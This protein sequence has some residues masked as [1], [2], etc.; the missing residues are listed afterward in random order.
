MTKEHTA[1]QNFRLVTQEAPVY[2]FAQTVAPVV[3]LPNTPPS[4]E[5]PEVNVAGR[6]GATTPRLCGNCSSTSHPTH[7]PI[8]PAV[9][10]GC[11]YCGKL[12][13]F[14]RVCPSARAPIIFC[15]PSLHSSS[16][17]TIHSTIH[18]P[19]KWCVVEL[20]GVCLPLLLNTAASRSLLNESTV[21]QL[22]PRQH[23]EVGAETL[24]DYGH[25]KIIMVGIITFS[26]CYGSRTLPMFTVQVSQH[27]D[28][29]LG[30]DFFCT[31][32]FSITDNTGSTILTVDT[33]R[34]AGHLYSMGWA[35]SL[36]LTT[37]CSS[38]Q[39]CPLF[40][41]LCAGCLLLCTTM[42][43]PRFFSFGRWCH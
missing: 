5:G 37:N 22:F 4:L 40:S 32:G 24:N 18:K 30:F 3:Q 34:T 15:H 14:S 8:C 42:S 2:S 6:Q 43:Q 39:L 27:G 23:I 1:Y 9:G 20:D 21:R 41:N 11:Q 12:N 28:N 19:F 31:L 26:V 38:T 29:L 33:G 7:A 16:P 36:P 10:Q 13:H 25:A 17:T 35:A